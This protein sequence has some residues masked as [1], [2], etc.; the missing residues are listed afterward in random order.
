VSDRETS[1]RDEVELGLTNLVQIRRKCDRNVL[2]CVGRTRGRTLKKVKVEADEVQEDRSHFV[3][4]CTCQMG[5]SRR[6][7][8]KT[9]IG[10]LIVIEVE[11]DSTRP[12]E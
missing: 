3:D 7:K 11:S 1:G 10:E 12:E 2:S 9:S 8:R 4:R 6:E 5:W